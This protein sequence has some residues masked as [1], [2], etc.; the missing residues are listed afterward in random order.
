MKFALWLLC[1]ILVATS[2]GVAQDKPIVIQA[3]TLL[4]GKG[5]VARNVGI[6]IEGAR[7]GKVGSGAPGA[8]T[9][10]DLKGLTVLPGW[11]DTH[12][13]LDWHFGLDGRFATRD[14][15]V[16]QTMAFEAENAYATL[17]AGFTTV[18][19][20]GAAIDKELRDVI[21]R[22]VLPGPEC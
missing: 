14:R 19:S 10:Y 4:D 20:V 9:V 22:G 11:I 16:S 2:L 1:V 5:G 12:V 17:M 6:Q 7:I 15:T 8:A 13:H 3:G 18:Q 21:A